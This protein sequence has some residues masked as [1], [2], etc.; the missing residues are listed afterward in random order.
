MLYVEPELEP[1]PYML[2]VE[3]ELELKPLP[4]LPDMDEPLPDPDPEF[5]PEPDPDII[6]LSLSTRRGSNI[7]TIAGILECSWR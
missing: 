6:E 2:Y 3:P 7:S 1:L 5:E 4:E